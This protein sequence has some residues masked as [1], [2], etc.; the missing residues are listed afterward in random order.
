M[1]TRRG[2]GNSP[3]SRALTVTE[4]QLLP[5][6]RTSPPIL[7]TTALARLQLQTV[8][9]TTIA[10]PHTGIGRVCSVC[11][12]AG[13]GKTVLLGDWIRRQRRRNTTATSFVWLGLDERDNVFVQDIA[14]N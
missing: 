13:A 2:L 8:L 7:G 3:S 6:Y 11:A 4:G 14:C 9:S 10:Q 1:N 12:P 5:H